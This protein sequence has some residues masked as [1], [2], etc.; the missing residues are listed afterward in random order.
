MCLLLIPEITISP[1]LESGCQMRF[2]FLNGIQDFEG[3][4]FLLG[5]ADE[6]TGLE[7]GFP[8]N[9]QLPEI[10]ERLLHM[11]YAE[12]DLR[13]LLGTNLLRV[14][15]AVWKTPTNDDGIE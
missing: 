9:E 8:G 14:A 3:C 11:G 6:H 2:V 15:K 4:L 12:D 10:V 1:C 5:R 7:F 13:G